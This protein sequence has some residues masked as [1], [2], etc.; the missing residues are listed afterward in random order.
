V[1]T[2]TDL[3]NLARCAHRVYLDAHGEASERLVPTTV[4]QLLWDEGCEHEAEIVAGLDCV[5]VDAQ[6]SASDRAQAT[7]ELMAAGVPLIYHGYLTVDDLAGEPDLL[8]R[9]EQASRFGSH[10]YVPVEI[11]SGRAFTTTTGTKPKLPYAMQLA[12]YS[13]LLKAVQ[14]WQPSIGFVIDHHGAWQEIDLSAVESEYA[15]ARA[16]FPRIQSGSEATTPGWKAACAQCVWR[17]HCWRE[18]VRVDDLT[19]LPSIGEPKRAALISIG[20]K[21]VADLAEAS[22]ALLSTAKGVG[23]VAARTWPLRAR[24]VKTGA[25]IKLRPWTPPAVDLE[26][27][28]DIENL[29]DPFVYLHGLLIRTAGTHRFGSSEFIDNDFG[30]FQPVCADYPESER[31]VWRRFL[32]AVENIDCR[33]SYAVYI[34]SSHERTALRRLQAT[35]G[36][37]EA[38]TRFEAN[39]IDLRRELARCVV[40]PT[41]ADGLKTIAGYVGFHWRDNDPGG[42]QSIAWWKEYWGDSVK[43]ADARLRV[44][45]YNE[46]DVRATFAI[47]DWLERFSEDV[48]AA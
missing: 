18:L 8:R 9:I 10:A 13:E 26:I 32:L 40:F 27:S 5:S 11:K 35:Y 22:P 36:G 3:A 31:D 48:Q 20:V 15:D 4:Q 29:S 43:R 44:L 12:A 6:L 25:P 17:D 21:T 7:L 41:D 23:A 38:L 28:Y 19:T 14:G 24:A 2:A 1:T 34:Y 39:I 16:K 30:A 33:G 46:D 47:R 37:S 42:G 45:A